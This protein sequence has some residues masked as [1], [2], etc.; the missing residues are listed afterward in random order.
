[1]LLYIST[2]RTG[3]YYSLVTRNCPLSERHI[4]FFNP[5][6]EKRIIIRYKYIPSIDFPSFIPYTLADVLLRRGYTRRDVCSRTYSYLRLSICKFCR[7]TR[8]PFYQFI[9][10]VR[11]TY[12]TLKTLSQENLI[13][14]KDWQN[15]FR[16]HLPF[17]S[18]SILIPYSPFILRPPASPSNCFSTCAHFIP[19][20]LFFLTR[21]I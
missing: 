6:I 1:M 13:L 11:K 15:L 18:A 10:P 3:R 21:R 4:F 5:R 12:S 2:L 20:P 16:F 7:K 17:V 9:H 14:K 8:V 19:P